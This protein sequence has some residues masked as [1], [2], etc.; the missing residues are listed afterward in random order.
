MSVRNGRGFTLIELMITVAVVAILTAVAFPSYQEHIRKVKRTEGKSALL[1]AA[2][3]QERFYTSNG[4]YSTDLAPLFGLTAG[5][6]VRSGENPASGN[7]DL[8]VAT[9]ALS[10]A[11]NQAYTLTAAPNASA[12]TGGPFADADC[13]SLTLTS[14]GVR[15][16]TGTPSNRTKDLCW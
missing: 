13:G 1:K 4:A 9:S 15:G 8:T 14:T 5:T 16:F 10:G 3:L 2:Q 6:A 11:A 7:Y 12:S